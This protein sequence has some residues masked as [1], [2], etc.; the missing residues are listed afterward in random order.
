M[1]SGGASAD[2][3]LSDEQEIMAVFKDMLRQKEAFIGKV[4]ELEVELGEYKCVEEDDAET[5][6]AERGGGLARAAICQRP[7]PPAG[8]SRR[9]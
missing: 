8:A 3:R 7:H 1:A 9:R 2:A 5:S 4:A 6:D